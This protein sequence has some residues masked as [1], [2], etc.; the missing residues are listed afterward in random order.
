MQR[1]SRHGSGCWF[2]A[3]ARAYSANRSRACPP[4]DARRPLNGELEFGSLVLD[5]QLHELRIGGQLVPIRPTAL[6]VLAYLMRQAPRPVRTQELQEHIFGKKGNHSNAV[7][8]QI[9]VLRRSLK[10]F[11]YGRLVVTLPRRGY[12]LSPTVAGLTT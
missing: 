5:W 7:W 9:H 4:P 10:P 11:G 3:Y 1:E 8:F 6:R 12:V 2:A